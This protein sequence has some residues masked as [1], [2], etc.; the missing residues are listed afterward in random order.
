[1]LEK[2]KIRDKYYYVVVEKENESTKANYEYVTNLDYKEEKVNVIKHIDTVKNTEFVYITNLSITNKKEF[3]EM[4]KL[5]QLASNMDFNFENINTIK[6][7][8]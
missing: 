8:F 7:L 3:N 4:N 2:Y 6:K 5:N 1:M